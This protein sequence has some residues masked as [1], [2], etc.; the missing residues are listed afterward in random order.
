MKLA[1]N[2][3]AIGASEEENCASCVVI[4]INGFG[5]FFLPENHARKLADDILR[6]ANYLWSNEKEQ[7]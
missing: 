4:C 3:I 6:N 5:K 1:E 7:S 2:F